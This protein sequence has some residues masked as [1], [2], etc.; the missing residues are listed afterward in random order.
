MRGKK[1]AMDTAQCFCFFSYNRLGAM[2]G[3]LEYGEGLGNTR[4]VAH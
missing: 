3:I 4:L 2:G 1:S